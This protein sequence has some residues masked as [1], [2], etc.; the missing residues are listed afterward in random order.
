MGLCNWFE[1]GICAKKRENQ[2]FAQKRKR[3]SKRVY[4]E[5]DKEGIYLTIKV[6][7]NCT[8]VLYRD[9]GWEEDNGTRLLVF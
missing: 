8:S 1:E 5:E 3:R 6:T 2:F 9:E 7:T 4:L